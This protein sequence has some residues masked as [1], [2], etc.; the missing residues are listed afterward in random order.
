VEKNRL[1]KTVILARSGVYYYTREEVARMSIADGFLDSAPSGI[2]NMV[3]VYRPKET[4]LSAKDKFIALPVT[5]KH[6]GKDVTPENYKQFSIG[7]TGSIVDSCEVDGEIALKTTIHL[8]DIEGVNAYDK[9]IREVSP[10][11]KATLR[12]QN[13]VTDSGNSYA[14]V[15]DS[16]DSANHLAVVPR[17][18]G[19]P[20]VAIID[21]LEQE[22]EVENK[23]Q[24]LAQKIEHIFG[25]VK[26]AEIEDAKPVTLADLP[27]DAK[28]F[29]PEHIVFLLS[30][31]RDSMEAEAKKEPEEKAEEK[32]DEKEEVKEPEEK[33]EAKLADSSPFTATVGSGSG[34]SV[35][36]KSNEE[37][38]KQYTLGG[39]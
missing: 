10:G 20:D 8:L 14:I 17:G 6:P 38:M 5:M 30:H 28:D 7:T 34:V 33:P 3:G 36:F 24:D 15:M 21:H 18:R 23:L 39:E 9:G 11:Y 1:N 26:K 12:W 2:G 31:V 22:E 25:W 13:G 35:K 19:G 16:I 29:K 32:K 27:K 4:L 37:F